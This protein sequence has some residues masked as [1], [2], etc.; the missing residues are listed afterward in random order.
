MQAVAR[1]E[2]RTFAAVHAKHKGRIFDMNGGEMITLNTKDRDHDGEPCTW[3]GMCEREAGRSMNVTPAA[4][5]EYFKGKVSDEDVKKMT[6]P[7]TGLI[8]N[9]ASLEQALNGPDGPQWKCAH[10]TEWGTICKM[11]TFSEWLTLDQNFNKRARRQH[12]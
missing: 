2:A 11:G 9:P 12:E 3:R 7:S 8:M 1:A 6:D 5:R 4:Y 10:D